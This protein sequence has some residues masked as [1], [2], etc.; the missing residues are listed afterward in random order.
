MKL[1]SKVAVITGAGSGI[2][3]ATAVLFAE[4]GAKVVV[5]DINDQN[6]KATVEQIKNNGGEAV[7][8]HTDV[9]KSDDVSAMIDLAVST[10]GGV[11]IMYSVAGIGQPVTPT[12]ELSEEMFDKVIAINLKG[13]FLCAKYAIPV[14]KKNGSGVIINMGSIAGV[15]PR[16]QAIAY[17]ASKGGVINLTRGLALELAGDNIRV[18]CI[19]PV[20]TNTPILAASEGHVD[21]YKASVPLGRIA[22]PEDMAYAALYLASDEARMVTGHA[23]NVDGGRSI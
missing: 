9:T 23:L 15:R 11:D 7:F 17:A 1:E 20:V 5:A 2:A 8:I 13:V 10:Y 19:N 6:G 18:N 14:M 3:K 22:E 12:E 21:E 4:E 16:S